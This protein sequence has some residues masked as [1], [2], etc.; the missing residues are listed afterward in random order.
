MKT[1]GLHA[2]SPAEL[3]VALQDALADGFA[4]TLAIVF[5]SVAQNIEEVS[6]TLAAAGLD[7]FG[8]TT[9]G[10]ILAAE[11]DDTVFKQSVVALLL[12]LDKAAYRLRLVD[13]H[14]HSMFA[15]AEEV[16]RWARTTFADPALLVMASGVWTDGEEVVRGIERG[17]GR[18]LP[19]YGGKAGDDWQVKDTFVFS[20]EGL[21]TQGV[22][23]LCLD[24]T[25]VSMT[26]L[27]ASGWQPVG[28][29]RVVTGSHGHVVETIDGVPALQLYEE[30]L[31]LTD[32][33]EITFFE[34]PLQVI[35][36]DYT[37][38]RAP[39]LR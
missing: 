4:P 30:Y 10:E 13:G 20:S 17:A 19:V 11:A 18:A 25:R 35:R 33:T 2:Q 28:A 27:A 32:H 36:E 31:G 1:K 39:M 9:A 8:A 16:G 29:E 22:L 24:Q 15:A 38:L 5:S 3:K 26:G 14:E 7:V 23:A 21:S 12:D 34:W 37:V 6:A